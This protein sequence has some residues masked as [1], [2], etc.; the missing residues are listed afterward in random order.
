MIKMKLNLGMVICFLISLQGSHQALGQKYVNEFLNIG[1]S[2]RA[3][4]MSGSVAASSSDVASAFWNPAGLSDI[5]APLQVSAM[6][7]EWFQGVSKYDY[8][9]LAKQLNEKNK[10]CLGISL[11]R[12]GVDNIPYTLNLVD[13][14]GRIN[15]DNIS[16]FSAADYALLLSYAQALK[17]Q[18]WS[19]GGS[20]KVIRRTIGSFAG[21]W[22]FGADLGVKYRSEKWMFGLMAKDVTTTFNSW[23]FNL[24]NREKDVFT[25]TGNDIPTSST[26]ITK[27]RFILAGARNFKLANNFFLLTEVDLD[28]TTDGQRNYLVSTKSLNMDPHAGIEFDY[29]HLFYLRA[30]VGN[31]QEIKKIDN[32]SETQW[33]LQPN[34]GAGFRFGVLSVDYALNNITKQGIGLYSHIISLTISF[35]KKEK[36]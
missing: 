36:S 27:P 21:S 23:V 32:P 13:A 8:I 1:V 30:G 25:Q 26:E 6:H 33:S 24:S 18:K 28:F 11:I 12:M 29:K 9:G 2:A 16:S 4:G 19:V 35:K 5:N 34:F 15:Y 17:N 20:V 14:D 22:G 31:I 7:A 10:S 3:H